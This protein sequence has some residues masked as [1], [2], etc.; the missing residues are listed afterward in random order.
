[1]KRRRTS[2]SEYCGIKKSTTQSGSCVASFFDSDFGCLDDPCDLG[3]SR[4]HDD[5]VVFEAL[6]AS[7]SVDSPILG[8]NSG[9]GK[10]GIF[11]LC[12][13]PRPGRFIHLEELP[14]SSAL[15]QVSSR[16]VCAERESVEG[17]PGPVI[18]GASVGV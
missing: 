11:P 15:S 8:M 12:R 10:H 17:F 4:W 3:S 14:R 6:P 2:N 9:G 1:M 13:R 5:G 18:V 16:G 7:F